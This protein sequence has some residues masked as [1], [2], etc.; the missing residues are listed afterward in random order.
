[1]ILLKISLT[2]PSTWRPLLAVLEDSPLALC[3]F[4]SVDPNDLVPAD[5]VIPS[6]E[7][8]VYYLKYNPDQSW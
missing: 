6:H 8:E 1:M 3:D 7:G 2:G 4:R 5:R